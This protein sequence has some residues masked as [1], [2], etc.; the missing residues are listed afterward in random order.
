MD[1]ERRRDDERGSE[2]SFVGE[3][4]DAVL[5]AHRNAGLEF[6]VKG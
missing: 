1:I 3:H 5:I 4:L 2:T 6:S